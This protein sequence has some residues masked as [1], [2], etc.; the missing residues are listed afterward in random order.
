MKKGR[1]GRRGRG[2]DVPLGDG[3]QN[4]LVVRGAGHGAD[5][6]VARGKTTG[7]GGLQGSLSVT[8]VVDALE[9]GELGGVQGRGGV[10]GVAHV[11]DGDVGVADDIAAVAELLGCRVVCAVRVGEGAELH[12]GDLDLDVEVLVGRRLLA[13][14][15]ARDDGRH[16]VRLGG[17]LAHGDTVAGSLL[18]LQAVGQRLARAEVDEV[19]VVR[20]RVGLAGAGALC[21]SV[22]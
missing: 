17:H 18:L 9:E 12:V 19:G 16:H 11:L 14:D 8:S 1:R 2:F 22:C 7:D 20:L 13:R 6:V 4:R 21:S 5:T 3:H 10:E 15:G